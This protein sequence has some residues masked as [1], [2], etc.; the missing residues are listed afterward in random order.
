MAMQNMN[1]SNGDGYGSV[2]Q[3]AHWLT[4]LL[5]IGSFSLGFYMTDLVLSPTKLRLYS[6]HKWI[7][8]TVFM[9]V[10]IRLGWRLAVPPPRLPASMPGWEKRTAE[11]THR[12]LYLLLLVTPLAG[13]LMSS[14][15]G[16]QTVYLG[17]LPLPNLLAKNPP[18]GEALEAVHATLAWMLLGLVGLHVAAALKHHFIDRD[19]VLSRMTPGV[20]PPTKK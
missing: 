19:D 17:V 9:L 8:V 14:A 2:A 6:Y 12:I 13:W 11:A 5:L 1:S 3:T 4:V 7:G 18:L 15:G 16:F 20:S 10:A